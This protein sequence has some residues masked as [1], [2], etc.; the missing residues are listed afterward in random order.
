[1]LIHTPSIAKGLSETQRFS[2][3]IQCEFDKRFPLVA[4]TVSLRSIRHKLTVCATTY[5]F[6]P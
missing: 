3:R 5:G 6:D 1:M 2:I 4:Q